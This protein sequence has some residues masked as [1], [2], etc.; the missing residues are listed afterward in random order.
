MQNNNCQA[1]NIKSQATNSLVKVGMLSALSF[2]LMIFEFPL[3]F[4][5]PFLKMDLSELPAIIGTLILGPYIGISIEFIK[6]LLNFVLKSS[7]GGIGEMANFSIGVA[8]LVPLGIIYN[9]NKQNKNF[10]FGSIIGTISMVIVASLLNYFVFIPLYMGNSMSGSE[11]AKY[12]L[13]LIVPFN[14]VKAIC[15]SIFGYISYMVFK[16][17]LSKM[18]I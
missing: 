5:P 9:K 3:P 17:V 10:I 13:G 1:T 2:I 14:V 7:T 8:Y 4:F 6:N 18:R 12:I 15:I 11:M 16:P